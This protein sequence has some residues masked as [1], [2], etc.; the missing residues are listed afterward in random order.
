MFPSQ[1]TMPAGGFGNLIAVPLQHGPRALG[2]SVFVDD[3]FRPYEDQWAFLSTVRRMT[4]SE[5][6]AINDVA[7]AKGRVL[8]V[9]LPVD[10]DDEEPWT[11]P[12]SR[13]RAVAPAYGRLPE[14]VSLALGNQLYVEREGL[15]PALVARLIRLAA[16]QNPEFYAAQTMRL[17]TFG[18]P[19]IISCAE[20]FSKQIALPRGCLDVALDLFEEIGVRV[21]LRDVRSAGT[22]LDVRFLGELTDE[23]ASA[24]TAILK[25]DIGV[26]A[27]PAAFGKT[28]VA[29]SIIAARRRNTLVLV[30]RRQLLDQW[31]ARLGAFLDID[32]TKIGVIGGG[33]R[34]PIGMLDVALLQ[35]LV[36][37]GEVADLVADYG[38]VVVGECHHLSAVS[39]EAIARE[40]KSKFVLGLSATVTRKDG[41]HPIIFM[42]CGPV[43]YRMDRRQLASLHRFG[44]RV[45]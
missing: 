22:D 9:R 8:G 23:Q 20:L 19:R 17:P 11:A 27:A 26:L 29:A 40:L 10:N 45:V 30:H 44:H 14:Q 4:L 15:P 38:H 28:V 1:D 6:R 31:V 5:V 32:R 42:Q 36:K 18:K 12:P 37:K 7:V 35:S 34:A 16:F 13:R 2:N 39:F 24:A 33:K 3:E 43:R 41:H 25:H 21:E